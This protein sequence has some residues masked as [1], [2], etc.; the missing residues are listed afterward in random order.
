MRAAILTQINEPWQLKD[1]PDPRVEDGQVLIRMEACG[2]CGTDVHVHRGHMP[3]I[4]LPIVPGHEPVGTIVEAGRGVIG[5]KVGDRVGVSWLQQGCGRCRACQQQREGQCQSSQSWV[6]LGGGDA[7]LMRAWARGCTLVPEGVSSEEAAPM[8]CAGYTVMSGLRAADPRPGERVAVLGI[9]GLGHIAVQVAKALGHETIAITSSQ[10]K[11]KPALELGAD[12][13][14]I[15]GEHAGKALLAVGGADVIV[16]TSNSAAQVSQA[17]GGLRPDG[18][19]VNL[20]ALDGPI[21]VSA[22]ELMFPARRLLGGSQG[23][24]RDLVE[25]LDL[26]AAGKVKTKLETYPLDKINEVRDRQE[27]GKVRF[28]AVIQ[29]GSR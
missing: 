17:F 26:V 12:H 24:R 25:L 19:M 1:V 3:F 10:D 8:F 16:S 18:R 5:L 4:K 2:L 22:F 28:R 29:L 13:A 9:G 14:V 6:T 7:E 23:A 27:A 20:G 21:Q 15:A 11:V